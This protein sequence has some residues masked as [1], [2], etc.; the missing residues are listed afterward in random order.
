MN[1]EKNTKP[2]PC[3]CCEGIL[4]LIYKKKELAHMGW[5]RT[6]GKEKQYLLGAYHMAKE[7]ENKCKEGFDTGNI[8]GWNKYPDQKPEREQ[9]IQFYWVVGGQILRGYGV[10]EW[11][12]YDLGE[13]VLRTTHTGESQSFIVEE[14][15]DVIYWQ[16]LPEPPKEEDNGHDNF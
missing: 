16:P 14:D 2:K 15:K 1:Q 9:E 6:K 10:L 8:T 3:P 13:F 4:F 7:L 12:A 5:Q 11:E